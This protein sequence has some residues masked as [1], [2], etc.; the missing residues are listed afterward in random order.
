M[1]SPGLAAMF[2]KLV[3]DGAKETSPKDPIYNCLGWSAKR[4]TTIWWQPGGATGQYWPPGV[5]D[6]FSFEC[7]VQL[8]EKFGYKRCA[9]AQL[10]ILYEKVAL[11]DDGVWFTHVSSQLAS[12]A[13][14][15]KLGPYE[16]IQHNSLE[17]LEG[18]VAQEYGK[19][20]QI[21]KRRCGL[22][23]IF[24]RLFFKIIPIF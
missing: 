2:P 10:E 6:D 16:D 20:R 3:G 1:I 19:V 15:S 8:F 24:L 21:M 14:T 9:G 5:P 12:G 22:L 4:D 23:G 13:W 11:Y 17:A 7:F 18:N